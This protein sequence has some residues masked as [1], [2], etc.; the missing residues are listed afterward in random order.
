[1]G[2]PNS[3]HKNL[4][5]YQTTSVVRFSDPKTV[6]LLDIVNLILL[7]VTAGHS[8]Q[9]EKACRFE[10]REDEPPDKPLK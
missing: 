7:N 9:K 1:M 10:H 3:F 4:F 2:N 6:F 5:N 8:T